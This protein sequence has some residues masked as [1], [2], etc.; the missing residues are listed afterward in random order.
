[1]N[2]LGIGPR[3]MIAGG[4]TLVILLLLQHFAGFTVVLPSALRLPLGLIGILFFAVGI[5][6]WFSS[7]I[8]IS[9]FNKSHRLVTSGVYSLSRNPLYAAFIVFLIP[10]IAFISG[11]F[12]IL[13]VSL[14]MFFVFKLQIGKAEKYLEREFG[15][16]FHQYARKVSQLIPFI[17]L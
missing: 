17:R 5:Y 13:L 6:F 3:L 7:L 10:G 4:V 12:L 1:M 16:E 8:L 15:S 2:I 14:A 11:N 9:S